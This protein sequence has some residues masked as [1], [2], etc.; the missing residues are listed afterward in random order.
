MP[1]A[2]QT[3][4]DLCIPIYCAN[5]RLRACPSF[6]PLTLSR[7]C[8]V[9]SFQ[10]GTLSHTCHVI[11][12]FKRELPVIMWAHTTF[13]LSFYCRNNDPSHTQMFPRKATPRMRRI[14]NPRRNRGATAPH[15]ASHTTSFHRPV[16]ADLLWQQ[17]AS[18]SSCLWSWH[19]FPRLPRS[20]LSNLHIV[21]HLPRDW[22]FQVG[23][24]VGY[25][26]Y[27]SV[28]AGASTEAIFLGGMLMRGLTTGL[29]C[30][31]FSRGRMSHGGYICWTFWLHSTEQVEHS[32][33]GPR[34]KDCV[35]LLDIEEWHG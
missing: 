8:H 4:A 11:A 31:S 27:T 34:A 15:T 2:L 21:P 22:A 13:A 12:L 28:F 30:W 29:T 5:T 25:L 10:T 19:I 20:C 16:H 35:Y 1:P 17:S 26:R 23:S 33:R 32:P 14:P 7:T 3:F 18:H 6:R 9:P 24:S